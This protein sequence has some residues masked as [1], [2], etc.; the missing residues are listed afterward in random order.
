MTVQEYLALSNIGPRDAFAQGVRAASQQRT[1]PRADMG[2]SNKLRIA[3]GSKS[4]VQAPYDESGHVMMWQQGLSPTRLV[5]NPYP[6]DKVYIDDSPVLQGLAARQT[7]M[8]R[9]IDIV[10]R[11]AQ[12]M[13]VSN[14]G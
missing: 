3:N 10:R 6:Y 9:A 2:R 14:N 4:Y 12:S 13:G 8:N 7:S 1:K 5:R 11:V